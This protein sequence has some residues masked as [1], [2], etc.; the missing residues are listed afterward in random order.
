MSC[1]T[2]AEMLEKLKGRY[3]RDN[4][5]QKNVLWGKYYSL[6]FNNNVDV[7][8]NFVELQNVIFRLKAIGENVTDAAVINKMLQIYYRE[9]SDR[10]VLFTQ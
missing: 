3:E 8:T 10:G 1:E 5:S 2:S 7:A 9:N 4:E 6:K